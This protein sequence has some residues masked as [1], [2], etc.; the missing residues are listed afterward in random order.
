MK[1][2]AK[3]AVWLVN[4]L[5]RRIYFLTHTAPKERFEWIYQTNFWGDPESASGSGSSLSYTTPIRSALPELFIKHQISHLAD[6]PCGDFNWMQH[7]VNQ[8]GIRYTGADIVPELVEK[9]ARAYS[10]DRVQFRC[11]DMTAGPL[12]KA[13]ALLCRD[14]LFHLSFEDIQ[15]VLNLFVESGTPYLLTT[16]HTLSP[17]QKNKDI[18]TGDFRLLDLMR[19]P[20]GNF[21]E[22]IEKIVDFK[23]PDVERHILMLTR[24]QVRTL[25]RNLHS[26]RS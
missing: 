6:I 21:G 13:D 24:K 14:A 1:T 12:P 3:K 26:K 2:L 10:S 11:L 22:P 8:T 18:E 15:K 20:F 7:V 4:D 25:A 17:E 5:R 19:E 16:S 9:L 23:W